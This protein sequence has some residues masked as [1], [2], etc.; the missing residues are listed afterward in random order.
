IPSVV[1]NFDLSRFDYLMGGWTAIF[2]C[3]ILFL[4]FLTVIRRIFEILLL[5]LVSPYFVAMMPLDDGEKFK[6]WFGMFMGKLFTGYGTVVLMKIYL[7]LMPL[8]LRGGITAEG[9]G[10]ESRIVMAALYVMGG[11]WTVYKAGSLLTG[12]VN[13][14]AGR[15][16]QESNRDAYGAAMLAAA[17][18]RAIKNRLEQKVS[19]KLEE[20]I[21]GAGK[22]VGTRL[23]GGDP[24]GSGARSEVR[25]SRLR[26]K[27]PKQ[28]KFKKAVI[29]DELKNSSGF[30]IGGHR[31]ARGRS[32]QLEPVSKAALKNVK[33]ST[34]KHIN[35]ENDKRPFK[36][37]YDQFRKDNAFIRN[38]DGTVDF[39]YPAKR[40]SAVLA[41]RNEIAKVR[42]EAL[43]YSDPKER[44]RYV[45]NWLQHQSDDKN[46]LMY[47]NP[48]DRMRLERTFGCKIDKTPISSGINKGQIAF[49]PEKPK[50]PN[51]TRLNPDKSKGDKK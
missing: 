44:S 27:P 11:A 29:Y 34:L 50:L 42:E 30:T 38:K 39:M 49:Y 31:P 7:M 47:F 26:S 48:A 12:L 3:V 16:E 33:K 28:P 10:G 45:T 9:M 13:E 21:T 8:I 22:D 51:G 25:T 1:L 14:A 15:L 32:R 40:K 17:P 4:C 18:F 36:Y 41:Q 46:S 23:Q 20:K 19:G 35:F 5:Y 2:L 43:S 24:K 6:Q 37:G